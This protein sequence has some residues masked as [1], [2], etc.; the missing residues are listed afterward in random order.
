MELYVNKFFFAHYDKVYNLTGGL[1][2]G[3]SF[4]NG[5]LIDA[6]IIYN[7]FYL[8]IFLFFF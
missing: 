2:Q 1:C 8:F 6:F 7:H 5:T 3:M 4:H